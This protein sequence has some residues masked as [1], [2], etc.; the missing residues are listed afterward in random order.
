MSEEVKTLLI[1]ERRSR[2]TAELERHFSGNDQ[3]LIRWR[4][5]QD[6]LLEE[7]RDAEAALLVADG[8]DAELQLIIQLKQSAPA[9][10]MGCLV[11]E[12]ASN[13]EWLAR[14][15]GTDF[16]LPDTTEIQRVAWSIERLIAAAALKNHNVVSWDDVEVPDSR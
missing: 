11:S 7:A 12:A 3:L 16:V 15:L 6:D 2:W 14:E 13:W 10:R 4:P 8:S 1:Y 9:L 5:H